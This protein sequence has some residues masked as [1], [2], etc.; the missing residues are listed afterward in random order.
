MIYIKHLAKD[1][2]L[3][4]LWKAAT[5][6]SHYIY[7]CHD[8]MPNATLEKARRDINHMIANERPLYLTTYYGKLLYIDITGDYLDPFTYNMYNG[9]Y[10]AEKMINALKQ[11][12]LEATVLRYYVK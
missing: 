10:K 7:Y 8:V 2:L 5:R 6:Y 3:Y 1:K 12:E 9:S 4:A 11:D